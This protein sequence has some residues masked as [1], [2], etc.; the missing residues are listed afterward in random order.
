MNDAK[1]D[2]KWKKNAIPIKAID[3]FRKLESHSINAS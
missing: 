2:E 1:S 3:F